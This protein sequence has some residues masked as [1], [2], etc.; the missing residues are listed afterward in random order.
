MN[1]HSIRKLLTVGAATAIALGGLS[2]CGSDNGAAED[3]DVTMTFWHNSTTGAGKA[4]WEKTV[5]AF[6][7]ANPG[8]T[9]NIQSIQNEEMDGKLQTALNSGDAPDIF[10]ARGGGKLADVVAAGQ[11]MDITDSIDDATRA[12][13]PEG[14]LSAFGVEGK[15]YGM[16]TAVLPGGIYYS[17]D[18]FAEAGVEG[19]PTTI[20]ELGS[21]VDKLKGAGIDPIAVGAKDAWPAAHWYYF[22]AVRA[23]SQDALNTAAETMEFDDPCWLEAGKNLQ[24][25]VDTEPFNNGFLT[26]SAQ[27]GAG[28]SAGLIANQKAA[29]ELMGAW[30]PGVIASLTPDEKPLPDLGWFPF[31]EVDGGEGEPGAMMGGV[32]GFTCSAQA[33][34]EECTAF[35][36]FFMQKEYQADYAEAFQTI[37]AN[38]DAQDVVKDPALLSIIE[39]YNEAPYVTVWL[40]TLFGQ[41]VG[42]ALNKGAVDLF[43]GQ[44]SAEDIVSALNDAAAKG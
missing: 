22:F 32:D 7:E 23:C 1:K 41:N 28:S 30:N 37:P 19:T 6:E 12:A 21:A 26:T 4:H 18:L 11:A 2:A 10:M 25:F 17:G 24:E 43:A 20:D 38:Q 14:V 40:D 29:M 13:V 8:V 9:I 36:N 3:G 27:Q 39:S 33:P 31:P 16:P 5:A 15:I 35:L 34:K 42:N 44:G